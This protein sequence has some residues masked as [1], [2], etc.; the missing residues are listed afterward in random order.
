MIMVM[1]IN[2]SLI[3]KWA[4]ITT[5]DQDLEIGTQIIIITIK[6]IITSHITRVM[7][8]TTKITVLIVEAIQREDTEIV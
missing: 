5:T 2:M 4:L 3:D 8:S 6:A 7:V 1:K